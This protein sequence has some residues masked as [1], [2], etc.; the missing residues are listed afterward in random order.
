M[1]ASSQTPMGPWP[2][3]P[4]QDP[5]P[6]QA[7]VASYATVFPAPE[8]AP[9][10][11][12]V[13]GGL[14]VDVPERPLPE[15]FSCGRPGHLYP[16][17]SGRR[18]AS[19]T[20]VVFCGTCVP[21]A[22]PEEAVAAVV[23][24]EMAKD[25]P[26]TP[27]D[28]AAAELT[29]GVAFDAKRIEAV[30]TAEREQARAEFRAELVGASQDREALAWFHERCRAVGRLCDDRALDDTLRVGEVL[31]AVDG[32]T[33]AALP[34]TLTWDNGAVSDP[35]GDGPGEVTLVA[36]TTARGGRAVLVL[37]DGERLRLGEHL[38]NHLQPAETC[39][40]P[41]CGMAGEDLDASDPTVSG[42]ILLD[43]AGTDSGPRW[44][45]SPW[46]SSAALAA[47]RA[48]LAAADQLAATDPDQ[49][50]PYRLVTDAPE[51]MPGGAW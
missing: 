46:C 47:A 50:V 20:P 14:V 8:G 13:P 6:L 29:A 12:A 48:E 1:T 10:G 21:D 43:V 39:T 38:L 37:D 23:A 3:E 49:Q 31:A 17:S 44:W 25:E 22:T 42:W 34:L 51:A 18:Y 36:C 15:C 40:T 26:V 35:A 7:A 28:I 30:R 2:P 24:A 27:R 16:D 32:R 45:C 9:V 19:G 5:R 33:P 41:G 11:P 4:Q